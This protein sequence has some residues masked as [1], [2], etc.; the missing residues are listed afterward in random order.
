MHME[1][2]LWQKFTVLGLLA[3]L[4]FTVPVWRLL[5]RANDDIVVA[6][7]ELTG[8]TYTRNVL[9]LMQLLQQ[10]RAL[11]T[12][13]L[14]GDTASVAEFESKRKEVNAQI[15]VIDEVDAKLTSLALTNYWQ[16]VRGQWQQLLA[17]VPVL[18]LDSSIAKHSVLV[19]A[20]LRF[21][22]RVADN[23]GLALDPEIDSYY[24]MLTAIHRMPELAENLGQLRS[25]GIV[26]L[27]EKNLA[28]EKRERITI[29]AE[30]VPKTIGFITENMEKTY[31]RPLLFSDMKTL[32][33]MVSAVNQVVTDKIVHAN[34]LD[35]PVTDYA[36]VTTTAINQAFTVADKMSVALDDALNARIKRLESERLSLLVT[37]LGLLAAFAVYSVYFHMQG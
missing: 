20:L 27:Q 28:P 37:A 24:L 7:K 17:D 29:S 12:A 1:I 18:T 33:D 30:A 9:K 14:S 10:H 13:V 19:N 3:V 2:K 11:A 6:A 4:M 21:N 15:N 22:R 31:S 16:D 23:S 26:V 5:S 25:Q 34:T 36:N 32:L 35:F 8:V